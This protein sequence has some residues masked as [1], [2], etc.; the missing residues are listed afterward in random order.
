MALA[1]PPS[2]VTI[3]LVI[4]VLALLLL[5]ACSGHEQAEVL[6]LQGRTMGTT[7]SVQLA[8]P[9]PDIDPAAL[10]QSIADELARINAQMS[11][12]DPDSSL[13]RFNQSGSTHWFA[14]PPELAQV[15]AEARRISRLSDGAF[16]VT[17]GRL[18]NLWGFGPEFHPDRIP[19]PEAIAKT[20]AVTGYHKL[21]V[22]ADPPA[23]C[24]TQPELYVDLSAIAK[25]YA[26]DRLAEVLAERGFGDYLVE[27]GGELRAAGQ[28]PERPWRVAIERPE[29]STRAVFRVVRLNDIAMA[30][31]GDYRNFFEQDGKLYSHTINPHRGRPVDHLLA[32]VSVLDES[33]MRADALATGLLVLGPEDGLALAEQQGIAAFFIERLESGYQAHMSSAFERIAGA[34]ESPNPSAP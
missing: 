21:A 15:V 20:L 19:T 14:V 26:V 24:K 8:N 34:S 13:S 30:T 10:Q 6:E 2:E 32:S 22:R 7:Y 18:V 23:L 3:R 27:V 9:P 12:Y 28:H 31:S 16:D 11:T 5:G 1:F 17:V 4:I 33:C 29:S 25:G